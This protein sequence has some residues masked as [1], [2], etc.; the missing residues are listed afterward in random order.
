MKISD[1]DTGI[2]QTFRQGAVI[3]AT[4]LALTESGAV[5]EKHQKALVRYYI[6]CGVGGIAIGVHSTQFEIRDCGLFEPLLRLVSREIDEWS[7]RQGKKILKIAGVCGKT[8]QASREASFAVS[9]G[10]HAAL[11]SLSAMKGSSL[12]ELIAHC[13]EV[14]GI[15]PIIGF[16]MQTSVGGIDLPYEFWKEFA[17]IPNVLGIKIAPFDRYK[18]F[19]VVRAICDAGKENDITLYT[20]NDDNIV[21]DLLSEYKIGAKTMRIK[22]GLLGH[23]CV[24]TKKAVELLNEI[25]SIIES[26][27]NIPAELLTRA[28]QITD[29]NAAFFDPK[30]KFAGCI[31]GLHEVLF[32]QGLMANTLCLNPDEVLSEGQNEEITRVYDAYPH[33]NDD[34][35]VRS[36]LNKWLT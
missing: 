24:W 29:S 25:H 36:N 31:P 30:N 9:A 22:G 14:A 28:G 15:M 2:L 10:Y 11:V 4:P 35:F 34:D 13:R 32:R 18:T 21:A 16:Y 3:P 19:D 7:A 20:G 8:E 17:T 12:D 23:W 5:D 26:G 27:K 1:I 6:D 33:L